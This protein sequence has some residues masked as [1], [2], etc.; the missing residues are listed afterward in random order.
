MAIDGATILEETML[1]CRDMESM[2]GMVGDGV[3]LAD[4]AMGV[5]ETMEMGGA[6][7]WAEPWGS[8]KP[9]GVMEV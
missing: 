1:P 6:R 7:M 8:L 3:T 9:W 5:V 2:G 4:G